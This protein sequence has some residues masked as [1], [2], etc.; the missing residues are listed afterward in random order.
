MSNDSNSFSSSDEDV[1]FMESQ[2]T[3]DSLEFACC[4]D[5]LKPFYGKIRAVGIK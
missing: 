5:M 1:C 2:E 3:L 4:D